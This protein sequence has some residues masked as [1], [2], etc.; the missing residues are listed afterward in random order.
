M[1]FFPDLAPWFAG[2]QGDWQLTL[3]AAEADAAGRPAAEADVP[4]PAEGDAA[5]P[6]AD[7]AAMAAGEPAEGGISGGPSG[8]GWVV[9]ISGHH[10]HN[11]RRHSP[12]EGAQFVRTTLVRGLL[13][14][15]DPV[16][17]TAGPK[18]GEQLTVK[19][20]G[21]GYPVIVAEEPIKRVTIDGGMEG[22]GFEG[23]GGRPSVTG[24]E[25]PV[26]LR[27]YSFVLQF[28]WQPTVPGG[29]PR[30]APAAAEPQF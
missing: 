1:E 15:G 27:Q 4:P 21:I 17:T 2:V 8:P 11:E 24:E 23:R 6:A 22:G 25:E 7:P 29:V 10:F 12:R 20:L 30:P 18:Q 3:A 19:D 14:H 16:T 28:V 26:V 9:E 13:G 5:E